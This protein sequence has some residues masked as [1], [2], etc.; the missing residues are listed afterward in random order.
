MPRILLVDDDPDQLDI[1]RLILEE[2][3]HQVWIATNLAD[4]VRQFQESSADSVVMDLCIP[5]AG[6][7]LRLIREIRG[8]SDLVNIVV[9]TGW[10]AD[11]PHSPESTMVNHVLQKPYKTDKLLSLLCGSDQ[12]QVV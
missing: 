4:A 6:D 5:S 7:G 10:P 9:A 3:G 1:R 12:A 8:A 2:A 11:L